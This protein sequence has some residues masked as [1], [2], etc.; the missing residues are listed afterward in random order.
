VRFWL[1]GVALQQ[2]GKTIGTQQRGWLVAPCGRTRQ[3]ATRRQQH[4][5]AASVSRLAGNVHAP[6]VQLDQFLDERQPQSGARKL[7]RR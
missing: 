4:R 6:L 2:V 7:A 5:K 1:E 3:L